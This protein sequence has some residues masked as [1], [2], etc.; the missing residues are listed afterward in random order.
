MTDTSD[1]LIKLT[2]TEA[3]ARLRSKEVSPLDLVEASIRRIET[4][5]TEVNALP[6]HCFDQA[7]DQAKSSGD[8]S[9]ERRR[10][11]AS[12][13]VSLISSSLVSVILQ[14]LNEINSTT[15]LLFQKS[16]SAEL[17]A[18]NF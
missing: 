5:D 7:R 14:Y 2:A 8:T 11:T 18:V 15:K 12:V 9:F 10:A 16:L 1:E 3:V 6:I 13:A 4:F 17:M